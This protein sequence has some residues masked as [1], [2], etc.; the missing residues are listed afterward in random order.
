[1]EE[2][3]SPHKTRIGQVLKMVESFYTDQESY[4]QRGQ[5]QFSIEHFLHQALRY[6]NTDSH[7]MTKVHIEKS[8][9][10][11]LFHKK[12]LLGEE[13]VFSDLSSEGETRVGMARRRRTSEE[14][15]RGRIQCT[16]PAHTGNTEK[17]GTRSA[18][19]NNESDFDEQIKSNSSTSTTRSSRNERSK[20]VSEVH[21]Q[22]LCKEIIKV[23]PNTST[24]SVDQ[25]TGSCTKSVT[26]RNETTEEEEVCVV[27]EDG[28]SN[29]EL[30]ENTLSKEKNVSSTYQKQVALSL[31]GNA[32]VE[33]EIKLSATRGIGV[34]ILAKESNSKNNA[35]AININS[36]TV[37]EIGG[38][39]GGRVVGSDRTSSFEGTRNVISK[40]GIEYIKNMGPPGIQNS[41]SQC[42][43]ISVFRA[44][45]SLNL[46][47]EDVSNMFKEIVIEKKSKTAKYY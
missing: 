9:F 25:S 22:N 32:V 20:C 15:S 27:N 34:G 41:G 16:H 6:V 33:K 36:N 30:K 38:K 28:S 21:H 10:G 3:L 37:E 47:M 45:Q 8:P 26:K 17:S 11:Q 44:M 46:V 1:M 42:Y 31:V 7:L 24:S 40:D 12:D 43:E 13:S 14:G 18:H 2:M 39:E 29:F 19:H 4:F 23:P 5:R 35:N